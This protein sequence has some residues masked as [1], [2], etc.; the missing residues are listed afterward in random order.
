VLRQVTWVVD[1]FRDASGAEIVCFG[2]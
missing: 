2:L 1:G